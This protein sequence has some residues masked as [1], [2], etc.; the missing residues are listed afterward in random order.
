MSESDAKA[1]PYEI[2]SEAR[3]PHWIAW[4]SRGSDNKPNRSIVIV[5]ETQ[6]EAE[7]RAREWAAH[8]P[9]R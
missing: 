7:D 3:G 9:Y 8:S 5:G 2:R 6:Q 4:I 1:Q